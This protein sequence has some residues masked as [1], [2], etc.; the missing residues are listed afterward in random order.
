MTTLQDEQGPIDLEIVNELVDLTPEHWNSATLEIQ[1]ARLPDGRD[2]LKMSIASP[3]GYRDLVEP[4]DALFHAAR[5][6][7]LLMRRHGHQ[8]RKATYITRLTPE[9]DWDFNAKYEY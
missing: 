6:L 3:E 1:S 2:S 4:T 7:V 8:L 5:K 9:E